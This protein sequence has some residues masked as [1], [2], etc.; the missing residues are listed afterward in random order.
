MPC[1]TETRAC[2][3]NVVANVPDTARPLLCEPPPQPLNISTLVTA[4]KG[5]DSNYE[6]LHASN[7]VCEEPHLGS[8]SFGCLVMY[9]LPLHPSKSG[10]CKRVKSCS[11]GKPRGGVFGQT[12]RSTQALPKQEKFTTSYVGHHATPHHTTAVEIMH[13]DS[14]VWQNNK[15]PNS[16]SLGV[17]PRIQTTAEQ[18]PVLACC[19]RPTL[20][21]TTTRQQQLSY[22]DETQGTHKSS[23]AFGLRSTST[24]RWGTT[25]PRNG[26]PGDSSGRI[27]ASLFFMYM[28]STPPPPR[29][30][31][32]PSPATG[33]AANNKSTQNKADLDR[34]SP[35][36]FTA[37]SRWRPAHPASA[38]TSSPL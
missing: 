8:R 14:S 34:P 20:H 22:D 19:R 10:S 17:T 6:F 24:N 7:K 1:T 28:C 2:L 36:I 18:L 13:C 37:V 3:C 21:N 12:S 9:P 25:S 35:Q 38:T 16:P 33:R 30:A 27:Y 5:W 23:S 26:N 4:V 15:Q 11:S 29:E 32:S 31:T